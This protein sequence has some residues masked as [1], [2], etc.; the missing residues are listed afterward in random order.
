M[1]R[2][3]GRQVV[4][5]FFISIEFLFDLRSARLALAFDADIDLLSDR[6]VRGI[7]TGIIFHQGS[8]RNAVPFRN[9]IGG[10]ALVDDMR[11]EQFV[12]FACR[13][14][15][16]VSIDN[17][18]L[19]DLS[20]TQAVDHDRVTGPDRLL[21]G[22][23]QLAERIEGF[24]RF[25]RMNVESFARNRHPAGGTFGRL[26]CLQH[27]SGNQNK[28]PKQQ[29]SSHTHLHFTANIKQKRVPRIEVSA[30]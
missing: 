19:Q 20:R 24:A 10:F 3:T 14:S 2:K 17:G 23:V 11:I 9:R 26:L 29:C 18:N 1:M 21:V 28:N 6:Q 22:I 25:H 15:L 12:H 4:E 5:R 27:R 8:E 13:Q 16:L 30:R 7:E